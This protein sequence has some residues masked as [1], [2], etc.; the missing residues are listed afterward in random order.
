MAK[1]RRKSTKTRQSRQGPITIVQGKAEPHGKL[2]SQGVHVFVDDQNL[3]YGII[4]QDYGRDFRIDFGQLLLAAARDTNNQPRSVGSAYI[5]GVI[6]DNDSFW[7]IVENRGFTV[8]RGFL[9]SG[10]RSKQ[11]DAYLITDM[12]STLY[13]QDGLRLLPDPGPGGKLNTDLGGRDD[14]ADEAAIFA[15]IQGTVGCPVVAAGCDA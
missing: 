2:I 1:R 5:A 9:G 11:D 4:N 3:F 13:E 6:P 14:K 12:V 10:K 7:K 8:R 15:G